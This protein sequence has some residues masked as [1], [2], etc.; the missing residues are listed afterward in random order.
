MKRI[1]T[2]IILLLALAGCQISSPKGRVVTSKDLIN[3][4][5]YHLGRCVS[6]PAELMRALIEFD[7][8]LHTTHNT[9]KIDPKDIAMSCTV[10]TGGKSLFDKGMT[11]TFS[12]IAY[13]GYYTDA[14]VGLSFD[15]TV[16]CISTLAY[17]GDNTWNFVSEGI[18]CTI[19]LEKDEASDYWVI[20]GR[21]TATGTNGTS[22]ISV[23][24]EGG[25]R[26]YITEH[27]D[28]YDKE[29]RTYTTISYIGNFYTDIYKGDELID[30]C[31]LSFKSGANSVAE[32]SRDHLSLTDK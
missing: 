31:S 15:V 24:E 28:E 16:D 5:S 12:N 18:D 21:S 7:E 2:F 17:E 8:N 29:E 1:S 6:M 25:I 20:E 23:T 14:T 26:V 4:S 22:S 9:H 3:Y 19:R 13:Y 11:W 30:Y 32:T 27:L 10:D